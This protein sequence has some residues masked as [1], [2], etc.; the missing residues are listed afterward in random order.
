MSKAKIMLC[1]GLWFIS[2][3][4]SGGGGG[5]TSGT[6]ASTTR[7]ATNVALTAADTTTDSAAS[8]ASNLVVK[9]FTQQALGALESKELAIPAETSTDTFSCSSG[10][11]T[12]TTTISGDVEGSGGQITSL[13]LDLLTST[14]FTNC[15]PQN[16][17]AT[18][19]DESQYTMNGTITGTGV[20]TASAAGVISFNLAQDGMLTISGACP[21]E[22]T[23]D[24][25]ATGDGT[26]QTLDCDVSGTVTGTA[27]GQ[28]VSCTIG[29]TCASPTVSGTNC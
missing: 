17:A 13:N 29:G 24:M 19:V 9:N 21:A 28:A 11:G 22:L 20:V 4:G 6:S 2:A 18:D 16:I 8:D 5:G 14:M 27:C 26:A 25:T 23:F 7:G 15:V 1:G 3:C 10:S 12:I